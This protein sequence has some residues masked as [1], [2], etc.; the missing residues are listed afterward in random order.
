LIVYDKAGERAL[1]GLQGCAEEKI[2]G[3]APRGILPGLWV[4]TIP[5]VS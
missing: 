5:W 1:E 3:W 4:P 2:H